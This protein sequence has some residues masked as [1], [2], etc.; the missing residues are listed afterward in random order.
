MIALAGVVLF[1]LVLLSSGTPVA[2][3]ESPAAAISPVVWEVIELPGS[4]G[5][6][7][8]IAEP[9]RYTM[10]FLPEE[11][12]AVRADCNRASGGYS[13]ADGVITF[14]PMA[15]TLALCPPDSQAEPFM[16]LLM[17]EMPFHF[18]NDG[19]LVLES[20][21]GE[22]KLRPTLG[23]VIWDWHEFQDMN[24]STLVLDDPQS[25]TLEF[26]PE[27]RLAIK[28]DCNRGFGVYRTDGP[29]IELKVMGLTR[30]LCPP[31]SHMDR[32]LR[33]IELSNSHVFRNGNLYLALPV[34]AG[35]L[36]FRP[37]FV[38]PDAAT[39]EAGS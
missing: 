3:P 29:A 25:Y 19:N 9:E 31:G 1:S 6:P 18:D 22:I 17:G 20:E 23:G 13:T 26:L 27:G 34:D 8:E 11:R 28:A 4:D 30:A 2:E 38:P 15:S 37:R 21:A 7:V 16:A 12:L 35:I 39:P 5:E 14:S 32:F 36:E 10:Q 33:D 24:D